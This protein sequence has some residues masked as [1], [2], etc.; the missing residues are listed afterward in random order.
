MYL[1]DLERPFWMLADWLEA[2][3]ND[4]LKAGS[5]FSVLVPTYYFVYYRYYLLPRYRLLFIYLL[6]TCI[7][8][9]I[10]VATMHAKSGNMCLY[11]LYAL[12]ELGIFAA[13]YRQFCYMPAI[14]GYLMWSAIVCIGFGLIDYLAAPLRY[15]AFIY[16]STSI[17]I[18]SY[19]VLWGIETYLTRKTGINSLMFWLSVGAFLFYPTA[20]IAYSYGE[21]LARRPAGM[22]DIWNMV[23][24]LNISYHCFAT[25]GIL[26]LS[27]RRE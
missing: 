1:S 19:L 18:S 25:G 14:C 24:M 15:S 17:L 20:Q 9:L 22:E 23:L 8:E 26:S 4:L 27:C 3:E 16:T 12:V 21:V 13:L 11:N 6:I 10:G 7:T 5:A 2:N